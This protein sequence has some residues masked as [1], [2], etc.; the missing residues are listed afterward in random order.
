MCDCRCVCVCIRIRMCVF[1]CVCAAVCVCEC[2]CVCVCIRIRMCVFKPRLNYARKATMDKRLLAPPPS[3]SCLP[4]SPLLS[5][6]PPSLLS[7]SSSPFPSAS[8][9]SELRALRNYAQT[10]S[11]INRAC[12]C[13]LH[14]EICVICLCLF[15]FVYVFFCCRVG[16]SSRDSYYY[17]LYLVMFSYFSLFCDLLFLIIVKL[18]L[19]SFYCLL[20]IGTHQHF[21]SIYFCNCSFLRLHLSTSIFVVY[22]VVI[23]FIVVIIVVQLIALYY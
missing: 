18:T 23:I 9:P 8:L 6:S 17:N 15:P 22:N 2:R 7:P 10:K 12:S 21:Y 3:P 13:K 11:I 5:N 4:L 16:S 20:L 1:V 14:L 19:I